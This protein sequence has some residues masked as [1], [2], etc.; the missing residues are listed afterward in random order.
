MVPVGLPLFVD[1]SLNT[2]YLTSDQPSVKV[3][4]F[5]DALSAGDEVTIEVAAPTLTGDAIRATATAFTAADITLPTLKEGRH[6]ILFKVSANGLQDEIVRT[7]DVVPSRLLR[8]ESH[9]YEVQPGDSID[10]EGSPDRTTTVVVADHNHGRYYPVLGSLVWT[11]GDR[12]DQML[13]RNMAQDLML[14]YFGEDSAFPAEFRASAYQTPDGGLAILPFADDDLTLS[15]RAAAIAPDK[16]GQQTLAQYL[17]NVFNDPD[18]TRERVIIAMFGLA[19][20]GEPVL[21]DIQQAA[22]LTDLTPREQLYLGL[23]AAELGDQDTAGR[24]YAA[25]LD[26]FGERRG[27]A[28]RLNVGADSDDILEAT[29][30]AAGLAAALGDDFAPLLFEYTTLNYTHE[31][32]VQLEQL[33]YLVDAMPRLSEAPV[34]VTYTLDGKEHEEALDRG[35]SVNLRLS[36]DQLAELD[37]SVIEG[38]A[39][40]ST[41]FLAPFDT[42]SIETDPAVTISR[43]YPG[44]SGTSVTV[45]E[46]DLVRITMT[47][48]L[49]QDAVDG[50]YQV[51]DLLPSG[52]RP[53]TRLFEQGLDKGDVSYPYFV[54]GQRVSFCVS[55]RF[56]TKTITYYAR[57]I[58]TGIYTAEPVVMQ[59]QQAQESIGVT[60]AL[61]VDIR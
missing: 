18:E 13:A 56:T 9:Y 42:G 15:A 14:Q 44:Q 50:C 39:G 48:D 12:L 59:S 22:A 51:S 11:Y 25:L 45:Q 16:F 19:A 27:P 21:L 55:R 2:S 47:W 29:S 3:R 30:L 24:L 41:T 38:T 7:I 46:G 6:E 36:P 5:G 8:D 54:E 32:L 35:T 26:A 31:T 57:V 40:V 43:S 34:R 53:V 4:A 49:T 52:L 58:G 10:L 28:M 20:L 61:E 1:V 37:L 60:D 33:T 23:A 17:R